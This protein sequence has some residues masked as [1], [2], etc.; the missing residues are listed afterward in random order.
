MLAYDDILLTFGIIDGQKLEGLF[1]TAYPQAVLR[2]SF[3]I[4]PLIE[5]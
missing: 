5:K 1:G 2:L 3:S 4:A